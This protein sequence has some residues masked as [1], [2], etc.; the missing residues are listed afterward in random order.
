VE[1]HQVEAENSGLDIAS[2]LPDTPLWV[3][4]N[5]RRLQQVFDNLVS[6][7]IKYNEPG[8]WVQIEAYRTNDHIFASVSDNGIGIPPKAQPKI[9]ERFFRVQS[10][11]TEDIRGTG[12]G[13][14]IVKSVIEKHKGR[15]WVESTLG[16]GSTFSFILPYHE[17][18][19]N[20]KKAGIGV[21]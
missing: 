10:P 3:C 21:E 17:P 16:Q 15:I 8:G 7:A 18:D 19:E 13:L 20:G 9:F 14:A 12:L 1:S 2:K 4:G 6:N 5:R 11:N